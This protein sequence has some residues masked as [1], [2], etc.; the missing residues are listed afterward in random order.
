MSDLALFDYAGIPTEAATEVRAAAERIRVR[1]KRTAEDIIAIG[2]DLVTVKERLPHGAFLPWIEAEFGMSEDTARN[3]MRVA[4]R[5]GKSGNIPDL[6]PSAL[7]ELAA[8]STPEPVRQ[9]I[10]AK[11]KA[12]ENISVEEVRRLKREAAEAEKAK[13]EAEARASRAE[14]SAARYKQQA[15]TVLD[16]QKEVV[17][18]A[19]RETA[20]KLAAEIAALKAEAGNARKALADEQDK[21]NRL[22]AEARNAAINEARGKAEA[23]AE[24]ELAKRKADFDR[25]ARDRDKVV[26]EVE[27]RHAALRNIEGCIAMKQAL[28]QRLTSVDYENGEILKEATEI[29]RLQEM[30]MVTLSD[31]EYEGEHHE[32]VRKVVAQLADQ[33]GKLQMVLNGLYVTRIERASRVEPIV[34]NG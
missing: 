24:E 28:D 5:Y 8:P 13:A 33:C 1:M 15:E 3:F 10:E 30:F 9:Q 27:R 22:I 16:G 19:E 6:T 20:Q 25:L 4:G 2:T 7:Y 23:L 18:K 14:A 32:R 26:E 34:I 12:G 11:A 17:A 29:M 21:A 31:I